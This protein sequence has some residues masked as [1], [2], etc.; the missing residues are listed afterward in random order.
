M[1]GGLTGSRRT[2]AVAWIGG[3]LAAAA[4]MTVLGWYQMVT[5]FEPWDDEG[6]VI[7]TIRQ[8]MAGKAYFTDVFSTYGPGWVEFWSS[9]FSISGAP[10][11]SY[12]ARIAVLVCWVL[13][14]MLAGAFA[15]RMTR[16]ASLGL[17]TQVMTF[18]A[19]RTMTTEPLH[20]GS[21]V[22]LIL[23]AIICVAAF[24]LD[25]RPRLAAALMGGL[26][27][28]L[29]MVKINV[30]GLAAIAA[31][32]TCCIALCGRGPLW[33]RAALVACVA[34]I[35]VPAVL[36]ARQ[37]VTTL[38][39]RF[40]LAVTA[41][42]ISVVITAWPITGWRTSEKTL[43]HRLRLMLMAVGSAI[44]VVIASC[45]ALLI[46]GTS[47]DG[48]IRG[49]IVQPLHQVDA[50]TAPLKLLSPSEDLALAG[51]GLAAC[52]RWTGLLKGRRR[53]VACAI[54]GALI[55]WSI[56]D[57]YLAGW[58]GAGPLRPSMVFGLA[59]A[60]LAVPQGDERD[61]AD[62]QMVTLFVV[63]LAVLQTLHAYPVAGSQVQFGSFLFVAVGA[64][65]IRTAW[66]ASEVWPDGAVVAMVI[67]AAFLAKSLI[68][69]LIQPLHYARLAYR[70]QP[71][72]NLPGTGPMR[73]D[74]GQTQS[75]QRL[76]R[77]LKRECPVFI[78]VPGLGSLYQ[79]TGTEPPGGMNM[80]SWMFHNDAAWQ[81]RILNTIK[82]EPRT[83]IVTNG[84]MFM[85]WSHGRAV[86]NRPLWVWQKTG[87]RRIARFGNYGVWVK[88]REAGPPGRSRARTAA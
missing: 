49:V 83:C 61:G 19:L 66:D 4:F 42:L 32:V 9:V 63:L 73:I 81:Q 8:F 26:I 27:G 82:D 84:R 60:W 17:L 48:L 33:R 31:L 75:L 39:Q 36:M 38:N 23:G 53:V 21:L 45:A 3:A 55:L 20:P 68:G 15:W 2:R 80:N 10:L 79:F 43:D 50:F 40:A 13:T 64:L 37:L 24:L 6:Y 35:A 70:T 57:P 59:L 18:I 16:H 88:T 29:M 52:A 5:V 34:I 77:F 7:L 56:A 44:A 72:L 65:L 86:P 69:G 87:R 51:L 78:S 41:S 25:R 76:T 54:A 67:T 85:F 14:S 58:F 12:T 71:A 1:P 46:A 28:F 62:R 22:C 47:V 11:T 30:G 74:P